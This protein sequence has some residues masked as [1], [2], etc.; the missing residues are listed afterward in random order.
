[1]AESQALVEL[2]EK[3][4]SRLAGEIHLDPFY[5]SLYSTDASN[6]SVQP[7]GVVIPRND[8]DLLAVVETAAE[9]GIPVIPRGGGTSLSGSAVGAALIL[10]CS[11]HLA[12]IHH[13]DPVAQLAEV[14]PG[15]VCTQL[16]LAAA[17]HGLAYGPDPA[18]ADR[19]TAGGMIGTNA[20]GAHSIRYGMTADHVVSLDAILA[21]GS[22]V[23]LEDI[24]L[25]QARSKSQLSSLE[26]QIY[27][28]ALDLR[29]RYARAVEQ[30]WPRTWRRSSGY[31]L[32]YLTGFTPDRPAA[33]Y[34]EP[35]AYPPPS[36]FNLAPLVCGS[37]GT[38]AVV[39]RAQLRL[40]RKPAFT[41]L[42]ILGFA[43]V[44]EACDFTPAVLETE[45][46]AVEL[47]PRTLI[48]RARAVPDYSRKLGFVEGDPAALLVVEYSGNSPGEAEARAQSLAGRGRVL[49]GAEQQ[50]DLWAVRKAGLGLLMSVPG[51]AKPITFMEDVAVPVGQLGAYV[52]EVDRILAEHGTY[53]EWYAH[54]SAGCLHMRPLIDLK[55][56]TGIHRMR[57]IAEAVVNLAISMRGAI[58]GEHGDG[59]SHTEFNE[60]LFGPELL[61]AF[62]ELKQAFDPQGILNPGKVVPDPARSTKLETQLRFGPEY[63]AS[64][65]ATVFAF[66]KEGGFAK[67]V[68]ACT[69]VGICRKADGVMCPSFQ[70]TR[71][72]MHS[73]RGRAN[74]LR[75]VISGALPKSAMTSR[76]L[77]EILDLC[78]E[79][80]G[81]KSECPTE[82]DMARMKAEVLNWYQQAHGTPLRSRLFGE[83]A[84]CMG[85]VRPMAGLANPIAR[86][87]PF[88]WAMETGMG[89]AR[90]RVLPPLSRR[91]FSRQFK[92]S[93]RKTDGEPV[94]LFVD[95]FTELNH[96]ELGHAAVRVLEAVGCQVLLAVGQGCCG[97]TMISKGLLGRARERA[98]QNV[99]ALGKYARQGVPIVG[100]E[101]SCLLMLRD[102]YLDLLP[103]DENAIAIAATARL[104][105][106]F[107]TEATAAGSSR[108]AGLDL[109]PRAGKVLLH[110]HCHSK[111]LVGS[112]PAL[113]MLRAMRSEVEEIQSGC[114]GMAGSFGYE[115][116]HYALSMQIGELKLFPRIREE[117]ARASEVEVVAPG[118]SCRSQIRDGTGATAS[119][120]VMMLAEALADQVPG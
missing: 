2:S 39:R 104:I 103:G 75:A 36:E 113:A 55:S 10:D 19:A 52:R 110:N 18:S 20:T 102:E 64:A 44:A 34:G 33:W 86:S 21:D 111:A 26:G 69:G 98:N 105:E 72:E 78:L 57:A 88:R 31:N 114:C 96:P 14:G 83:I 80:K 9:F 120:P 58:S 71:M 30:A 82:V 25:G 43:G 85:W 37:E 63:R 84:A 67:A 4:R 89:V 87:R 97:R 50:A 1:M 49:S 95:T 23:R 116:E 117:A 112:G 93:R 42:V 119:H 38:L 91:A 22:P 92:R 73:T 48:Q 66:R 108:L 61:G 79:C 77:Y 40:V 90:Q 101:P 115:V 118:M 24:S 62:R 29:L 15:V 74:A 106:E 70:A 76:E 3:L 51:D 35:G 59:L 41:T 60:R 100:L 27:A 45:P 53:G 5:R 81:C 8:E 99:R 47:I 12:Q 109:T 11:Q 54:A 46:A 6:H 17:R 56:D 7:L 68:E 16:N 94:V 107:L 13:I 32:N 65:P 28:R